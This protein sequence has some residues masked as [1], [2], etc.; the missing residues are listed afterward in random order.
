MVKSNLKDRKSE[1]IRLDNLILLN[2][3]LN[4]EDN[5]NGYG[6]TKFEKKLIDKA[7]NI[8]CSLGVQPFVFPTARNSIQLEYETNERY[9]EFEIFEDKV[10]FLLYNKEAF[11][12]KINYITG[13][14]HGKNISEQ[15]NDLVKRFLEYK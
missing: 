9:L 10:T 12:N 13:E 7:S 15:I 1:E 6:V 5:W 14:L 2:R 3:F 4:Y 8:V 11:I